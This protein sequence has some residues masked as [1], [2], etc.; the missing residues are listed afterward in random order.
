[1][2]FVCKIRNT[3]H[4][5]VVSSGHSNAKSVDRGF[6][7][8]PHIGAKQSEYDRGNIHFS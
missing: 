7:F 4:Q 8:E 1:M 3:E 6:G 5:D 2:A